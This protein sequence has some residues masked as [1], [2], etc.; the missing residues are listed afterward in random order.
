[1]AFGINFPSLNSPLVSGDG[2]I[3]D[4]WRRLFYTL[5]ERTGSGSGTSSDAFQIGD[6]KWSAKPVNTDSNWYVADG[7]E[8]SRTIDAEL[9]AA[10]G[11]TYG[12]GNGTTTFNLPNLL[13]RVPVG[14]GGSYAVGQTGGNTTVTLTVD[15]IPSHNHDLTD[16]GHIHGIT[17]PGHLHAGVAD[18][19][20]SNNAA[21]GANVR[22]AVSGST[23]PAFTG[24]TVN[25]EVTGITIAP[26]GSGDP[27]EI[28]QPWIGLLPLIKRL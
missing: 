26:V 7:S 4:Q 2:R 5:W 22:S 24:I 8:K 23:D 16:P 18:Q 20:G 1:M 17:D 12:A 19:N 14:A 28:M 25:S 3:T 9:F 21:N 15:Q 6:V 13:G 11:T 10:I 27:I